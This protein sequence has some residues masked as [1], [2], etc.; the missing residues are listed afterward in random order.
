MK[1]QYYYQT[2]NGKRVKVRKGK[3]RINVYSGKKVKR[4]VA[5]GAIPIKG[6]EIYG[7]AA[8]SVG[9]RSGSIKGDQGIAIS[10]KADTVKITGRAGNVKGGAL[11]GK[12][13]G[14]KIDQLAYS[15]SNENENIEFNSEAQHYYQTRNG[16]RVLVRKGR[17]SRKQIR[18]DIL[19]GVRY[20]GASLGLASGTGAGA[21]LV[22][23]VGQNGGIRSSAMIVGATL[24]GAIAAGITN[25]LIDRHERRSKK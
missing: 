15:D 16:K 10:Q 18:D 21:W 23:K 22:R 12:K 1:T 24:G 17:N 25:D 5:R 14:R 7:K 4:A 20:G 2:R 8:I 13:K 19:T 11:I 3:N 6:G 9:D